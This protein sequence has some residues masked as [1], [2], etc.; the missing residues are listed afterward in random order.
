M[1]VCELEGRTEERAEQFGIERREMLNP[2]MMKS[3]V[4]GNC[5]ED[6][7]NDRQWSLVTRN[8]Y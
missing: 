5:I 7:G 8:F 3:Q 2:D 4:A 6:G 1:C